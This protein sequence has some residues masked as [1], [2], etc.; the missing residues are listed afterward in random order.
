MT[1]HTD[2]SGVATELAFQARRHVDDIAHWLDRREPGDLANELRA[3]A[4]R[5]PGTFL[6]GAAIGG[7]LAGRLTRGVAANK[8]DDGGESARP[9]DDL[10]DGTGPSGSAEV[11][12]TAAGPVV[13]DPADPYL[14]ARTAGDDLPQPGSGGGSQVSP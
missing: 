1:Q 5:Q 13:T 10:V 6:L 2:Q 8:S 9:T 11:S 3:F 4:R 7:V 14:T 12:V